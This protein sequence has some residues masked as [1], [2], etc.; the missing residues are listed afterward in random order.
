MTAL[1]DSTTTATEYQ[2]REGIATRRGY[3]VGVRHGEPGY[4]DPHR[5]N[6]CLASSTDGWWE[7]AGCGHLI[8]TD[9]ILSAQGRY[10]GR[11]EVQY[12]R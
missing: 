12:V 5:G 6:T 10:Y 3:A 4:G 8:A 11:G 9:A 1:T 7:C 2:D